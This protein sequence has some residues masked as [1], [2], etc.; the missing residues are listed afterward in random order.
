M[1][2]NYWS[3]FLGL[4]LIHLLVVISP[5][6]DFA[7]TIRQSVRFGRLAGICTAMGIG[8]G[9][10][11]HVFYTLVGISALLHATPWLMS[12][13]TLAGG[14]YIIYLG[15]NFVKSKPAEMTSLATDDTAPLAQGKRQ[16]FVM[17]FMTNATNPKATLFFLA[18][19]TT[20]VSSAT[21]LSI[22]LFYGAWM[23][24]VNAAW[25]VLVSVLFST[26]AIRRRFVRQGH[27][28]ER[29]MGVML[30]GYAAR[31]LFVSL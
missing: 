29:F 3:E 31:L 10:S 17:G 7:V 4:A 21:P 19:F 5:G 27:W 8:A 22:Q 20:V 24:A 13:A 12:A 14:A 11:V 18:V 16:A 6:P 28:F 1:L 15:V 26:P 30:I 25:F 9:M 2:H 23:C